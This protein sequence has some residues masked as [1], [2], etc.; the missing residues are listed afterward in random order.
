MFSS[1]TASQNRYTH[2]LDAKIIIFKYTDTFFYKLRWLKELS[3]ASGTG[4]EYH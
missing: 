1:T 4:G 2:N 3:P